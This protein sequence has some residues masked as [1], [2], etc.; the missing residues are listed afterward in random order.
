MKQKKVIVLGSGLVV[1]PMA[2]DLVHDRQF[3]V[4]VVDINTEAL[5]KY[6]TW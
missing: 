3:A 2:I 1:A 5:K 4:S 6:A